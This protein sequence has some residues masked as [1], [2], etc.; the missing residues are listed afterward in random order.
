MK[1]KGNEI[2]VR[3][4]KVTET[5]YAQGW[6]SYHSIAHCWLLKQILT[7]WQLLEL[8]QGILSFEKDTKFFSLFIVRSVNVHIVGQRDDN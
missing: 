3:D 6:N 4:S 5:L 2:S 7:A 8:D 1:I